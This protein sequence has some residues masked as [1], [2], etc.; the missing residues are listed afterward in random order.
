MTMKHW[1]EISLLI[2]VISIYHDC[3]LINRK[4]QIVEHKNVLLSMYLN[5]PDC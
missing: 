3:T 2:Y 4:L 5:K 1:I